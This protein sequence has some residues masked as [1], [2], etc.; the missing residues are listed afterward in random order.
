MSPVHGLLVYGWIPVTVVEDDRVGG[1][2]IDPQTPGPRTQQ[3]DKDI[4]PVGE[5][6]QVEEFYRMVIHFSL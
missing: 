2:Q 1:S 3:E 4:R 5:L 6:S